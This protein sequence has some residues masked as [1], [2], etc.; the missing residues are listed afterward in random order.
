MSDEQ[1]RRRSSHGTSVGMWTRSEM[2]TRTRSWKA[3]HVGPSSMSLACEGPTGRVS[4]ARLAW[5]RPETDV[6]G[7][8]ARLGSLVVRCG[9]CPLRLYMF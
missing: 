4:L 9:L 2:P 5:N 7:G 3:P 8:Y 6:G 1:G